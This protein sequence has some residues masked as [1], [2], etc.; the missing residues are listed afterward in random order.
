M[1]ISWLKGIDNDNNDNDDD[2]VF[3]FDTYAVLFIIRKIV[4]SLSFS[5]C[6]SDEIDCTEIWS[7]QHL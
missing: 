6:V 3:P 4:I 5:V 7:L 2:D 1:R